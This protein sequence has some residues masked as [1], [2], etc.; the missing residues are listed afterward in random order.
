MPFRKQSIARDI[1]EELAFHLEMRV[2]RLVELGLSP[3]DARREALRQFGDLDAVRAS[4]VTLDEQRERARSRLDMISELKQD[5][6]F[7]L[8]TLR[9]NKAFTSVIVGALAIGIGANTAIFTLIDAVMMRTLPVTHPEQLVVIGD[10]AHVGA[11]WN[12]SVRTDVVSYPLYKDIRDHNRLFSGVL[13]SGSAPRLDM[14]VDPSHPELEHPRGRYVSAN[15]FSLLGVRAAGGRIFD[16]A[17]DDVPGSSPVAVISHGYW[18]RRFDGDP[19]VIGRAVTIDGI[20]I[21]IIGVAPSYYTG[22]IVGASP[23]IWL[24]ITMHDALRP[25]EKVLNERKSSWLLLLGRLTPGATLEQAQLQLPV[26]MTRDIIAAGPT[27]I[28]HDFLT[29]KSKFYISDGSTGFSRVRNTFRAPLFTLMTG[30]ALLLCIICAN[31]ANL[32]LARAVA[33]G[34]EMSVRLALGAERSR[35]VRQLLTESAVLACLSAATGLLVAWWGSHAL[36]A[37]A[38]DGRDIPLQTGADIPVLAF[39]VLVSVGA[40]GLFGLAP[41]LRASRIDLAQ[42]MRSGAGSIAGGSLGL[43]R[44][45]TPLGMLLVI[46]QVALSI[47]LLVAATML[48]RSL[49]NVQTTNVGIDRDHLVIIDVDAPSRGYTRAKLGPFA[50]HLRDRLAAV[51]GVAAVTFSENG[52]FSGTESGASIQ[53]PGFPM[54][55]PSDSQIAYDQVG[56]GYMH[57]LGAHMLAGRDIEKSDEVRLPR[58]A[59]VNQTLARFYFG[60]T[61]VGRFLHFNDT[62]AVEIVGVAADIRDHD[63]SAPMPRRVYFPFVHAPDSLGLGWPELVSLEVRTVGDPSALVQPLRAAILGVDPLLAIDSID[64]LPTLLSESISQERLLAQLATAFGVLALLLAAIGLYGVMSYAMARR[65]GEI[66]LRIALGADRTRVIAM[67]LGDA[68]RLVGV[69]IVVGLALSLATV[70]FLG[71]ELHDISTTDP[72]SIGVA[73]LVLTASAVAAGLIPALRASR[74]SPIVALRAE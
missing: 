27:A 16:A 22:E 74:V 15:Y 10:P 40:V 31:V 28:V 68:L 54:R 66:G 50:N 43:R 8:R 52:I 63:L 2:R 67:V 65:T 42:M 33:R 59:V 58:V 4:C 71:S 3:D 25:H 62:L 47:V 26:L 21:T 23:D 17:M 69:G 48:V 38:S 70:R 49:R 7:A 56:A 39:T 34:R 60:D 36:L 73:I 19:S 32:L 1:D 55:K 44:G 20:K 72:T 64:P 35:L 30:V 29:D 61:A 5:V 45:R 14:Q 37:L 12:G 24:P 9:R 13:A 46:G 57:A 11:S 41:A 51:P 6:A 18:E 53:I